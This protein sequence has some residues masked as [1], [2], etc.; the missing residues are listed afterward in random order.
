MQTKIPKFQEAHRGSMV[1]VP[2]LVGT[3]TKGNDLSHSRPLGD[4][5]GG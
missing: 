3:F 5:G 1:Q 4:E 2:M